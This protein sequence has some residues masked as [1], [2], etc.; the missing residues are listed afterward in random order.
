MH[1]DVQQL[2]PGADWSR[3]SRRWRW[4]W[5]VASRR[6]AEGL[7]VSRKDNLDPRIETVQVSRL[8]DVVLDE[9]DGAERQRGKKVSM[10]RAVYR[11]CMQRGVLAV[12]CCRGRSQASLG[13]PV[14]PKPTLHA[15]IL[16]HLARRSRQDMEAV[17]L[18]HVDP[19][20]SVVGDRL[21]S[22][23]K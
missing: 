4:L 20:L 6:A 2:P 17:T 12:G 9:R 23:R 11:T 19:P 13:V 21:R 16:R 7:V 18:A 5:R 8:Q 1:C 15:Q 14:S 10:K 22:C 3:A